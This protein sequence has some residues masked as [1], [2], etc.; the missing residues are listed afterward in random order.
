MSAA[1]ILDLSLKFFC[2]GFM[3]SEESWENWL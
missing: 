2:S 3:S 1:A